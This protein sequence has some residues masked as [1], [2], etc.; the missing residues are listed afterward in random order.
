MN[1]ILIFICAVITTT[2]CGLLKG[3]SGTLTEELHQVS[4]NVAIDKE[5]GNPLTGVVDTLGKGAQTLAGEFE[6]ALGLGEKEA[7]PQTDSGKVNATT[8][9]S[10]KADED[11]KASTP[12]LEPSKTNSTI[13][14]KNVENSTETNN[15]VKRS[16]EDD[17][18]T[19]IISTNN[20]NGDP[21]G[22]DSTTPCT[23]NNNEEP[24]NSIE[25]DEDSFYSLFSVG[26]MPGFARA[27]DGSCQQIEE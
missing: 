22:N 10:V 15:K 23:C 4:E 19:K 3:L 26:C 13:E 14:E 6:N 1:L 17:D 7:K 27:D 11:N 25:L 12:K 20:L 21:D 8:E 16:I 24:G 18:N 2:N 9:A 5:K